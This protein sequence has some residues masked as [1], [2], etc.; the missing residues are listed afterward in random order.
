LPGADRARRFA[1][2]VN[3]LRRDILCVCHIGSVTDI[4]NKFRY[5]AHGTNEQTWGMK[6][7]GGQ[8]A[9]PPACWSKTDGFALSPQ[10]DVDGFPGIV[11]GLSN[12]AA[13]RAFPSPSRPKRDAPSPTEEG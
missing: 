10:T 3:A 6:D 4:V 13:K 2:R 12:P 7:A 5:S 9:K 1:L 8:T 11:Q